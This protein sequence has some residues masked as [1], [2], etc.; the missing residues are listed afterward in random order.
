MMINLIISWSY[1]NEPS[2][3]FC[4]VNITPIMVNFVTI[5]KGVELTQFRCERS[6]PHLT[7]KAQTKI[8]AVFHLKAQIKLGL[9]L[10]VQT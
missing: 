3:I 6:E 1:H 7:F 4:H 9:C 2:K 10:M 8:K 5:P